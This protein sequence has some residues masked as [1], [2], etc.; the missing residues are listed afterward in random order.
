[1]SLALSFHA[2]MKAAD[3]PTELAPP[4]SGAGS[5]N[6]SVFPP[7]GGLSAPR[8]GNSDPARERKRAEHKQRQKEND[9]SRLLASGGSRAESVAAASELGE[10]QRA[11]LA[12]VIQRIESLKRRAA[13]ASARANA[14]D[15][16][17]RARAAELT[18]VRQEGAVTDSKLAS[19]LAELRERT[20]E[21]AACAAELRDARAAVARAEAAAASRER[22]LGAQA[23]RLA[24]QLA[25]A[26]ARL[27]TSA[28][29]AGAH[30][31][32]VKRALALLRAREAAE[33]ERDAAGR[34]AM[35]AA[36]D[37]ELRSAVEAHVLHAELS[38]CEAGRA[39]NRAAAAP[40]SAAP[41]A[42]VPQ[43]DALLLE[44]WCLKQS[45]WRR[46][47]RRRWLVLVSED[48]GRSAAL[49]SLR[50][51]P[52][53]HG[54][55]AG[56]LRALASECV[57]IDGDA[58]VLAVRLSAGAP[59]RAPPPRAPPSRRAHRIAPSS[60]ARA[61]PRAA[62]ELRTAGSELPPSAASAPLGI[63]LEHPTAGRLLLAPLQPGAHE[64]WL[65]VLSCAAH[66]EPA[67]PVALTPRR[68]AA[69]AVEW[70]SA[71]SLFGSP[72]PP[73]ERLAQLA[74]H[75]T[76]ARAAP[77]GA[78]TPSSLRSKEKRSGAERGPAIPTS[79]FKL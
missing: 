76:P 26:Q 43:L 23:A 59:P 44:G 45:R 79:L 64:Q 65:R 20:H 46:V 68:K 78:R 62:A 6:A 50:Q 56:E 31:G 42:P 22:E 21:H 71:A 40:P 54:G 11:E 74:A 29:E 72:T 32:E 2:Q 13:A 17:A 38:R 55:G 28:E 3:A 57:P 77:A 66:G 9:A 24:E 39:P 37:A 41:P 73:E 19:A 10:H 30:A 52:R 1:M 60:D 61:R 8:D 63:L 70:L 53:A 69:M 36:S 18:I 15:M 4:S 47:W 51:Q 7:T 49:L 58:A 27:L 34:C 16:C 14:T 35:R 25:A 12:S 75:A 33:A 48:E 5:P 67:R